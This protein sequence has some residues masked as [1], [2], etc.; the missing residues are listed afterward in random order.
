MGWG[1]YRGRTGVPLSSGCPVRRGVAAQ[2]ELD[3]D[4]MDPPRLSWTAKTGQPTVCGLPIHDKMRESLPRR[5]SA[6]VGRQA[7]RGKLSAPHTVKRQDGY[8]STAKP[9]VLAAS[10]VRAPV[11]AWATASPSRNPTKEVALFTWMGCVSRARL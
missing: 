2:T 11:M 7:W 1:L 6:G 3:S 9:T 5:H 4:T 8:L 10:P